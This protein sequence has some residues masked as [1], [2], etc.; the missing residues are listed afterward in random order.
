MD[1]HIDRKC[2]LEFGGLTPTSL[3]FATIHLV[4]EWHLLVITCWEEADFVDPG[5]PALLASEG[6]GKGGGRDI[7]PR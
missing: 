5:N 1:I 3:V 2:L 6:T 4:C 7:H